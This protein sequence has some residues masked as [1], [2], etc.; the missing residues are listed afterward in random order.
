MSIIYM[1]TTETGTTK[2]GKRTTMRPTIANDPY[3]NLRVGESCGFAPSE[4][5]EINSYLTASGFE[6]AHGDGYSLYTHVTYG[7]S[8]KL[9]Y[10]PGRAR[11]AERVA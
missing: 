4:R 5:K 7:V 8:F 6:R 1:S 11:S 10:L 2:V 9:H 3:L